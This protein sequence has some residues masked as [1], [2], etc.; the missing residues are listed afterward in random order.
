MRAV[1]HGAHSGWSLAIWYNPRWRALLSQ[2]ILVIIVV[3]FGYGIISNTIHNIQRQNIASGFGFLNRTASFGVSQ[4]LIPYSED[5]SYGRVF[6]VGLLNTVLV[7]VIGI[8]LATLLGFVLGIMRLS[9]N[10][11]IANISAIYVESLRNIPPLLQLLFWYFAVLST[12][13]SP[14][15]S[16]SLSDVFFLN[17]RGFFIPRILFEPEFEWVTVLLILAIIATFFLSLW[18]KRRHAR[19]GRRI[20]LG[21]LGLVLIVG[22][23]TLGFFVLGTPANLDFPHLKGFT[24]IGGI[25]IIPECIAVIL[26]LTLFT[27][28]FI[29]EIVRSGIMAVSQGQKEAAAALGLHPRTILRL[30][31][32]PQAI[33]VII[34]PLTSEYLNL[35]KNSSLAVA[36]GFPEL[37]SVFAGTTLNQVGQAVEIIL[38]TMAVYLSLSIL[39]SVLM[40]WYNARM[41]LVER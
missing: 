34:P 18:A 13:P 32:M 4:S 35:I 23:P 25:K 1:D 6:I 14:R 10:W 28:A 11:L 17:N 9:K 31:V 24:F 29:A 38:M 8:V 16:L 15:K 27:A 7:S 26:A 5:Q 36:V 30:V 40:N 20:P 2:A 22:L 19:T 37:V 3:W 33:R 12:L 21:W 39:S 41:A